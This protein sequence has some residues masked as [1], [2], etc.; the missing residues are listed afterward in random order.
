MFLV[1]TWICQD[2]IYILLNL[3]QLF[4]IYILFAMIVLRKVQVRIVRTGHALSNVEAEK[5]H[6]VEWKFSKPTPNP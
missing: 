6:T 3:V 1:F 5:F 2:S 4:Y